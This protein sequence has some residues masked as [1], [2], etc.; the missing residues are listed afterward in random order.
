M[1]GSH[2]VQ[3]SSATPSPQTSAATGQSG[4]QGVTVLRRVTHAA[5]GTFHV[6][7]FIPTAPVWLEDE[8]EVESE[9]A[10]STEQSTSD[11]PQSAD[12]SLSVPVVSPNKRRH[13]S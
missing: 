11:D 6:P 1:S 9:E 13:A 4:V 10:D 8:A 12:T 2:D 7:E 5:T 3:P